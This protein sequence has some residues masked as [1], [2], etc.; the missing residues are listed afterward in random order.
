M[1]C[2]FAEQNVTLIWCLHVFT[3]SYVE[4]CRPF[5]DCELSKASEPPTHP[6]TQRRHA[7]CGIGADT[8]ANRGTGM[9]CLAMTCSVMNCVLSH[10]NTP[11]QMISF[12]CGKNG[13]T[14]GGGARQLQAHMRWC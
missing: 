1:R 11:L 5:A 13:N 10:L 3:F 4:H 2:V 14:H 12:P 6:K 7:C 8:S 9:G